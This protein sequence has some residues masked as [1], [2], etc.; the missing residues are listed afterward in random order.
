ERWLVPHFEKMLYD[1]ALLLRFGVH[2]WQAGKSEEVRRV[3]QEVFE[4]LRTEMT[5]PAG[6]FYSTLDAD[7]E[8]EEG[9][10]YLW[11][12]AEMRS[13]LSDDA[14][15]AIAY[16]GVTEEGNFEDRN[17]LGVNHDRAPDARIARARKVLYA[18]RA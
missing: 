1:N 7:S 9:K 10:F 17:I 16:W 2:L 4:W 13:L 8:G 11:D 3:C 18:A 14:E 12:V 6:G 5:S 15:A